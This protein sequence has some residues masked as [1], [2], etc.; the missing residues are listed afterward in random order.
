MP[1]RAS[2][3]AHSAPSTSFLRTREP[4]RALVTVGPQNTLCGGSIWLLTGHSMGRRWTGLR[5]GATGATA[6]TAAV[7]CCDRRP[8]AQIRATNDANT[9]VLRREQRRYSAAHGTNRIEG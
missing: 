6:T 5:F 8:H 2:Q 9:T 4:M 1:T 3:T 7:F